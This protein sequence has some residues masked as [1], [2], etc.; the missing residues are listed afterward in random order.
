MW[1]KHTTHLKIWAD[2]PQR[3]FS[4][5]GIQMAYMLEKI[6]SASL[7]GTSLVVQWLRLQSPNAGGPGT[8][9]GQG[10]RSHMTPLKVHMSQLNISHAATKTQHRQ[11]NKYINEKKEL[12]K[13]SQGKWKSKPQCNCTGVTVTRS[14]TLSFAL[15]KP[16]LG[17]RYTFPFDGKLCHVFILHKKNCIY[18]L[19]VLD[20]SCCVGF[21]L[22]VV[23]RLLIVVSSLVA[24]H[25]L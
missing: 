18:L 11:I 25:W 19:A 20:L 14:L 8:I 3:H 6:F 2:D 12:K 17:R 4:K 23:L 9:S 10:A 15:T 7:T 24:E 1:N 13:K 21:S 16:S 22:V 5:E